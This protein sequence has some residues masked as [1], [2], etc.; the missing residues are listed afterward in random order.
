MLE[1]I[2]PTVKLTAYMIGAENRKNK[3]ANKTRQTF[4][5]I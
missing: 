1:G 4:L 5:S 3:I 2:L